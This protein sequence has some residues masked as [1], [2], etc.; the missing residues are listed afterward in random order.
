MRRARKYS[1]NTPSRPRR[2]VKPLLFRPT[3]A[4]VPC[5][6]LAPC[7]QA[8]RGRSTA[9]GN[10]IMDRLARVARPREPVILMPGLLPVR[11]RP[12]LSAPRATSTSPVRPAREKETSSIPIRVSPAK[13][14]WSASVSAQ[15]RVM[16][17]PTVRHA[18]RISSVAAVFEVFMASHATW[19]SKSRVWPAWCRAH[20]RAQAGGVREVV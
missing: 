11:P 18:I 14:S 17:A 5:W 15:T 8:T 2:H 3:L 13:G 10:G 7:G 12:D 1:P 16:I 6:M 19:E 4:L 20:A 9:E